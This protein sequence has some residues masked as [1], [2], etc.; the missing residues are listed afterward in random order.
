MQRVQEETGGLSRKHDRLAVVHVPFDQE[1]NYK[2]YFR[3][4]D[5]SWY[6]ILPGGGRAKKLEKAHGIKYVP[7]VVVYD[8]E[9]GK[10]LTR[11]GRYDIAEGKPFPLAQ[12]TSFT[13]PPAKSNSCVT[14]EGCRCT[15]QSCPSAAE[16]ICKKVSLEKR[17]PAEFGWAGPGNDLVLCT[18][19]RRKLYDEH[20]ALYNVDEILDKGADRC[21][22]RLRVQGSMWGERSLDT[23][24]E[25]GGTTTLSGHKLEDL[26]AR[27][28]KHL[29]PAVRE[30]LGKGDSV[31]VCAKCLK[32][33]SESDGRL[34]MWILAG[35]AGVGLGAY[36][37]NPSE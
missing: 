15:Y 33:L 35:L 1:E 16:V 27:L 2:D 29:A 7:V 12:Q 28:E 19:H 14:R 24:C 37:Y 6:G 3:E 20:R 25:L 18:E 36:F 13:C 4:G 10:R 31:R 11:M 32:K 26:A 17:M 21:M 5:P 23:P 34:W 30:R 8:V 22:M 9:T